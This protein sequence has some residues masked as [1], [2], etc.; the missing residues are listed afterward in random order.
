MDKLFDRSQVL[1]CDCYVADYSEMTQDEKKVVISLEPFSD[2]AYFHLHK[3]NKNNR[4]PYLAVNLEEYPAFRKGIENCECVFK[5][6][7][8]NESSWLMFLELKYCKSDHIESYCFKAYSQ[9]NE[10]LTKLEAH[11]VSDRSKNNVYFVYSVPDYPEKVPFGA[12]VVSQN[13][14]LKG[15][16]ESG[17][18]LIGDCK[19]LIATP[20]HLQTPKIHI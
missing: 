18:H 14:I 11:G 8:H 3:K 19:V 15:F 7:S 5:A 10:I 13:D 9:M 17:I 2:I 16:E 1:D 4:I 12:W 20:K 6:I